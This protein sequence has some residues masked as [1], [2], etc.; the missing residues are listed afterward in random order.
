MT[1]KVAFEPQGDLKNPAMTLYVY[2]DGK[3][4]AIN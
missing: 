2:E 1:A 4:V 3:K